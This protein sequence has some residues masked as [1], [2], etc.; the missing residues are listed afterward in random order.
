MI[1]IVDDDDSV[2]ESVRSLIRSVGYNAEA[3]ASAEAFLSSGQRANTD[4]IV[5]D[6]RMPGMSGLD[7]QRLLTTANSLIPIIFITAHGD[8]PTRLQALSD[9]AVD[10]LFKPF[11]EEALLNAVDSALKS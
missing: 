3:F 11:N 4:C 10:F 5:L 7:L 6:V 1:A 9:G 8:D 2:R